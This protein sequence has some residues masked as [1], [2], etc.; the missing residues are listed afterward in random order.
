MISRS[1]QVNT[2]LCLAAVFESLGEYGK[3]KLYC[4][5]ALA[6]SKEIGDK[7]AEA[8]CYQKE[9]RFHKSLGNKDKAQSCF[10][11]TLAIVIKKEVEASTWASVTISRRS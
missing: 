5:N 3:S 8:N 4:D 2:Y 11:K 1:T 7:N 10:E 6:I 9:G